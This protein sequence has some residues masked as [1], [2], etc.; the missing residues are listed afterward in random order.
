MTHPPSSDHPPRSDL[1]ARHESPGVPELP[2]PHGELWRQH[3]ADLTRYATLLVG[4]HD[5]HDIVSIAFHRVT[6]RVD[7]GRPIANTRAYLMRSVTNAATDQHRSQRRR[8]ERDL[9]AAASS[10]T[11]TVEASGA[12][13]DIRR[14]VAELSVQ[15]RA[16][17]Y[18]TYWEDL[19]S[20]DI[21]R[22]LD[23]APATVRR[24]LSR[25]RLQL[26]KELS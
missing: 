1:W 19:D 8:Q 11:S 3:A 12:E 5:A 18:F 7:D 14:A 21:A 13:F 24:H 10:Q 9:R 20:R 15:Q 17:V 26:R 16:V 23:I 25:A 22:L 2:L 6:Q 4:P